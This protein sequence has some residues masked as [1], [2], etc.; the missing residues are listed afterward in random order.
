MRQGVAVMAASDVRKVVFVVGV[1]ICKPFK[2]AR[3]DTTLAL[4]APTNVMI[5]REE[6]VGRPFGPGLELKCHRLALVTA[7]VVR[8]RGKLDV[9]L[10][11]VKRLVGIKVDRAIVRVGRKVDVGQ[12]VVG[13][14]RLTARCDEQ[15][16]HHKDANKHQQRQTAVPAE[17]TAGTGEFVFN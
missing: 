12:W 10:D 15:D 9:Q 2:E 6:R 11:P 14:C 16:N 1:E 3:T 17:E 5:G 4:S 13:V 8:N 7:V